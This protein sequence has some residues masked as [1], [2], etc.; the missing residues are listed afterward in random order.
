VLVGNQPQTDKPITR[1]KRRL[2]QSAGV[3]DAGRLDLSGVDGGLLVGLGGVRK[4]GEEVRPEGAQPPL[5]PRVQPAQDLSAGVQPF[6]CRPR[7]AVGVPRL[8]GGDSPLLVPV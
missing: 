6:G 5:E 2:G 7:S 3:S 8:A 4:V 1:A